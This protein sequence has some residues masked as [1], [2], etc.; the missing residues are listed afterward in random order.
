MQLDPARLPPDELHN[1]KMMVAF[2]QEN[3]RSLNQTE[4]MI[5]T[6]VWMHIARAVAPVGAGNLNFRLDIAKA[7]LSKLTRQRLVWF[8]DDLRAVLQC[9]PFSALHTSHEVKAFGWEKA[10]VCSFIDAPL[11]LLIYGPNAWLDVES[12]CPRSGEILRYKVKLDSDH[13]LH[14]DAPIE[15]ETWRIWMPS[16]DDGYLSTAPHGIRG[17]VNAFL[18]QADFDTYQQYHPDP[19]PGSL[20]TLSQ[21]VYLSECLLRAYQT[22]LETEY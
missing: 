21:A 2:V 17:R 1:I 11:S 9:P 6:T 16:P 15:A 18:T 13:Q 5:Y 14:V 22:A 12:T 20:Y 10:Y 7:G 8:D 3:V 4:R 19:L